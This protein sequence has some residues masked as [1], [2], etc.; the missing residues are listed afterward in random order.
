MLEEKNTNSTIEYEYGNYTAE[1]FFKYCDEAVEAL[2]GNEYKI[3]LNQLEL[4]V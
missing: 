4:N 1:E 3:Q 2:Y